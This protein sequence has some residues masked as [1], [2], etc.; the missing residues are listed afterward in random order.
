ML[1][2]AALL[3]TGIAG[4]QDDGDGTLLLNAADVETAV[5]TDLAT[6]AKTLLNVG[7]GIA[8]AVA[9]CEQDATCDLAVS[10]DELSEILEIVNQRIETLAERHA[11]GEEAELE[12]VVVAYVDA[13]ERYNGL[14]GS[15]ESLEQ[16]SGPTGEKLDESGL[17][18][19]DIDFNIFMDAEEPIE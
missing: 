7:D 4:A 10:R 16:A 1:F 12:D 6:D 15:V 8:I 3:E 11:S 13:R 9:F 19:E 17:P 2:L 18:E 5:T 14:L